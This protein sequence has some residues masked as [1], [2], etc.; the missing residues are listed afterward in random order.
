M[1]TNLEY[2]QTRELFFLSPSEWVALPPC[3]CCRL[4]WTWGPINHRIQPFHHHSSSL[5]IIHHHPSSF[6]IIYHTN[7]PY[8]I[9]SFINQPFLRQLKATGGIP[10]LYPQ[11][12]RFH[13]FP[14]H[15]DAG[16]CRFLNGLVIGA[17]V[18]TR[19]CQ[20]NRGLIFLVEVDW[21]FWCTI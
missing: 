9:C 4:T 21:Q 16:I 10:I 17:G 1:K 19:Q 13:R 11:P 8:Y 3:S 12:L 2:M 7:S 15:R 5:I 6:I 18:L 14:G 20:T